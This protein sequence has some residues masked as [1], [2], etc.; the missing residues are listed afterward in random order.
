MDNEDFGYTKI[1]IEKPKSIEFLK[2]DEKFAKLKD[3]DKILEKLQELEQNP[4]DFK[5]REEFIKFLGVKLKKAK[6]I[7]S[8]IVT[9]PTI[10]KKFHSKQTYKTTMTQK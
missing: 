6:K 8:S 2:D 4:Q 3:K 10:L 7:S 5:N 9:K 1:I